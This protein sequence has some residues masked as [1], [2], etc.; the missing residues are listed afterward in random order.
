MMSIYFLLKEVWHLFIQH[1][2]CSRIISPI[3]QCHICQDICPKHSLQLTDN[4]W[5]IND[6]SEC[7]LCAAHCPQQV[8]QLDYP[9]LLQQADSEKTLALS[10]VHYPSIPADAVKV[11]CLQQFSP[12]QL[13]TL[14]EHYQKVI[15]YMMPA[16]CDSCSHHWYTPLLSL[17]LE[18]YHL[19]TDKIELVSLQTA[20]NDKEQNKRRTFFKEMFRES[21]TASGNFFTEKLNQLL[22]PLGMEEKKAAPA[23]ALPPLRQAL[24]DYCTQQQVEPET[25]LPLRQ[26]DCSSCHFCGA[27][28]AVCPS[29]ALTIVETDTEKSLLYKPYLCTQCGLCLDI[30]MEKKLTWSDKLTVEQ[31]LNIQT[32]RQ[33]P[34][35][36]CSSCGH[37]YH[38]D[39]PTDNNLCRFCR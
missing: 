4:T 17:Q 21:K 5:Q 36:T 33:S 13:L 1:H 39:P 18:Q 30:C 19:S 35:Y 15:I 16:A 2:L 34:A 37:T 25:L 32:L 7:G 31:L 26:L 38:S 22:D 20:A 24:A 27:C 10:C 3:S 9:E 23:L 28:T 14:S 6:C 12:L 8:F 11:R 29:Q